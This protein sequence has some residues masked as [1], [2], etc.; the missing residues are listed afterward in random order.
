MRRGADAIAL[1]GEF[2][3][4][5]EEEATSFKDFWPSLKPFPH[6]FGERVLVQMET[7]TFR[8]YCS[9]AYEKAGITLD[10]SKDALVEVG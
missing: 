1:I 8:R 7:S 3:S 5:S 6:R 2:L 10:D 4:E 9:I